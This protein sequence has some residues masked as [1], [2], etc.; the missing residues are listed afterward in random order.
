MR[1]L[2]PKANPNSHRSK[3]RKRLPNAD[4]MESQLRV[5]MERGSF[6]FCFAEKRDKQVAR[7]VH[8]YKKVIALDP[9]V[10]TFL[11]GFDSMGVVTKL[12]HGLAAQRM[13]LLLI[14]DKIKTD[15][16]SS[17]GQ[18]R[19]SFEEKASR[20][21]AHISNQLLDVHRKM[22]RYLCQNYDILIPKFSVSGMVK[23]GERKIGS[24][25]V[26]A[27]LGLRHYQFRQMLKS[28]A[29]LYTNV[30]VIEVDEAY[31]TQT[32]SRCGQRNTAV[33][34]SRVYVC[35]DENCS[36]TAD[37]DANAARN[38][39]LRYLTIHG[40]TLAPQCAN[41]QADT[42]HTVYEA[43][44]HASQSQFACDEDEDEEVRLNC[45]VC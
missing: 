22:C 17:S 42:V 33:G 19:K 6:Y 24:P 16:S 9:G 12:G 37:R 32:C 15:A 14:L 3:A 23:R 5:V 2:P 25:T 10:K 13:R 18:Q 43:S 26:R 11:T 44:V 35:V 27:M 40:I 38:I 8:S 31:T 36:Y 4:E 20:L 41:G 30:T 45:E 28:M 34:G 39:L 7:R 21:Q 29:E 1:T